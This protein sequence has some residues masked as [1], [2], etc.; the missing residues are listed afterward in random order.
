MNSLSTN[1]SLSIQ[2]QTGCIFPLGFMGLS[3]LTKSLAQ[4]GSVFPGIIQHG[5]SEIELAILVVI[6]YCQFLFLKMQIW[7]LTLKRQRNIKRTNQNVG[8]KK[9]RTIKVARI[10]KLPF[11]LFHHCVFL[12]HHTT[13]FQY[14]SICGYWIK[15][16]IVKISS[17]C[18]LI[19]LPKENKYYLKQLFIFRLLILRKSFKDYVQKI[20]L[21]L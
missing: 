6:L 13:F 11:L 9:S 20:F 10:P 7:S 4:A 1:T 21:I 15:T 12:Q 14:V 5:I 3:A 19:K 8:L 2:C 17:A 16:D 18:H